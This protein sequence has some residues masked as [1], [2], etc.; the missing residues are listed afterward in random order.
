MQEDN[1]PKL[2]PLQKQIFGEAVKHSGKLIGIGVLLII[3]GMLGLLAETAFSFA[4]ISILAAVALVGGVFMA[5][6]A[7]QSKG[8]KSFLIQSLFAALYIALGVFIWI[9]PVAALEG[10]TIWLAALF[11]ITGVMRLIAAFQNGQGGGGAFMP[12][13]SGILSIVLGVMIF[14]NWPEASLWVPGMLL[15]IEFLL[16]GWMLLFI[17]L[18]MKTA[19]QGNAS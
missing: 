10:L 14:N 3:C 9:S 16:Q 11:L 8:W 7:F 1:I 18:A 13:I 15:A 6:H 5:I 2:S 12:A 19:S 4:S 17:G